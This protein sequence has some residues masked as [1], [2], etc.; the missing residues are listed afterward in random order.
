[1]DVISAMKTGKRFKPKDSRQWFDAIP[2][3]RPTLR[4]LELPVYSMLAEDWEVEEKEP[5]ITICRTEFLQKM[6]SALKDWDT[7]NKIAEEIG[8]G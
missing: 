1:M 3:H 8:L 6:R 2:L 7:V 5:E 4:K